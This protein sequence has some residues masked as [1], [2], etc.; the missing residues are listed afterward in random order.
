MA[1]LAKTRN[2]I[3][4]I[5]RIIPTP[6]SETFNASPGVLSIRYTNNPS[7]IKF[8]M[9]FSRPKTNCDYLFLYIKM[10]IIAKAAELK[11]IIKYNISSFAY[12]FIPSLETQR[13]NTNIKPPD[14]IAVN[15]KYMV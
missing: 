2:T 1:L 4:K 7:K 5:G 3:E 8:N 9:I 15:N 11:N 12:T 6:F 13:L 14:I 10:L